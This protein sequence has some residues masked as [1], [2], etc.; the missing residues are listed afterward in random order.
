MYID[1][2]VRRREK[3]DWNVTQL[4][5]ATLLLVTGASGARETTEFLDIK[6]GD[7]SRYLQPLNVAHVVNSDFVRALVIATTLYS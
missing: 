4:C 5:G 1:V 3:C 2:L 6:Y 7:L